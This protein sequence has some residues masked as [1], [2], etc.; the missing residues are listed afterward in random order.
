MFDNPGPGILR[1]PYDLFRCAHK[2][3][4][5]LFGGG[6]LVQFV[7]AFRA[8]GMFTPT[9]IEFAFALME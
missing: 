2:R 4:D 6:R 3:S 8:T 7:A 1:E 5:E 9:G